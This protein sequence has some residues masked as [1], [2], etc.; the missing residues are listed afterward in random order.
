MRF[1]VSLLS[2]IVVVF[3]LLFPSVAGCGNGSEA[4]SG[5]SGGSASGSGGSGSGGNATGGSGSGGK[6][7]G[8]GGSATGGSGATAT[9]GSGSGGSA[10]GG[11]GSGGSGGSASGGSG[12]SNSG[13]GGKGSGGSVSGSGGAV[14]SGGSSGTPG[15]ATWANL[16]DVVDNTCFGSD[17]HVQGDRQP[18][19]LAL[20]AAP[21]SDAD[22]YSK[23]TTYK[24]AMCGNRVLV[25]PGAPD[26]SAFYLA[27]AG[28]C[29]GLPQ[30]PFGC[31][32]AYDNCTSMDK[33]D[34][35]RKWIAAG[36]TRP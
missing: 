34:G 8:S 23:L 7:T 15:L 2:R 16:R 12:G 28:M 21:L 36:A 4:G 14:A 1:L 29:D 10:T 26:E 19:L 30:M 11:N 33:L 31:V 20:S 13:S 22:L 3:A 18:F 35:I 25:K 27:Q 6:G 17:C 5:G 9:G 24:A 32:P